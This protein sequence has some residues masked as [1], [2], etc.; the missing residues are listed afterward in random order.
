[1]EF[2]FISSFTLAVAC[3]EIKLSNILLNVIEQI[4][5]RSV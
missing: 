5:L 1:M 2:A 3:S 4:L